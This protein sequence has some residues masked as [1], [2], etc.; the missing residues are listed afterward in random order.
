MRGDERFYRHI[1]CACFRAMVQVASPARKLKLKNLIQGR[2]FD[3]Q[4]VWWAAAH[5]T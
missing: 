4:A 5:L 3:V 1:F 2:Q